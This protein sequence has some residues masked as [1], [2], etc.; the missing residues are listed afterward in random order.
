VTAAERFFLALLGLAGLTSLA[1]TNAGLGGLFLFFLARL[2]S[3]RWRGELPHALLGLFI[4]W[5]TAAALLSPFRT[6]SVRAIPDLWSWTALLAAAALAPEVRRR[7]EV[8]TL[9]LSV[10]ALAAGALATAGFFFGT[11]WKGHGWSDPAAAGLP[12]NAFFSHHLTLA[13]AASVAGFFLAGQVVYGEHPKWRRALLGAGAAACAAA[14]LFSQGRGYY[15][16]A[17]P[18]VFLLAWGRGPKKALAGA[19]AV[20]LLGAALFAVG[21]SS[22][23]QRA[24]SIFDPSNASNAERVCLWRAALDQARERPLVGWG[25]GTYKAASPPYRAP[26]AH[27]VQHPGCPPGFQT[28]VHAHNL[29]LMV[30]LETGAIGLLLFLTLV[31]ALFIGLWRQSDLALR[32]GVAAALACFLVG[33]LFEFNGGDAEVASLLFVVLGLA[34]PGRTPSE[35]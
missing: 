15:L 20:L 10:S 21:P 8:Y 18:A 5:S 14:L 33:G 4:A 11:H 35:R 12:A 13:G 23:R 9:P 1:G 17:L 3:G 26:Y 22:L 16:A 34:L 28:D 31:G 32:Y 24:L 30:L 2:F 7:L 25:P 27:L 6:L 19:L 29:Y